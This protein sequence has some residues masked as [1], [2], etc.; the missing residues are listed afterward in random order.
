MFCCLLLPSKPEVRRQ[1][2]LIVCIP[3][4]PSPIVEEK[5]FLKNTLQ[6]C[7]NYSSERHLKSG[8]KWCF[9]VKQTCSILF[10]L[11]FPSAVKNVQKLTFSVYQ[12]DIIVRFLC[13]YS[14]TYSSCPY[15]HFRPPKACLSSPSLFLFQWN[16]NQTSFFSITL[17]Q[18]LTDIIPISYAVLK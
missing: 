14:G 4:I 6:V 9:F 12:Q 15:V 5:H 7:L 16:P 8:L 2:V 17:K 11:T 10:K 18:L 1:K 3:Q 13:S